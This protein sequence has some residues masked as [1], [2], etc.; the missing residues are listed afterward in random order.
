MSAKWAN[1]YPFKLFGLL[2]A[3]TREQRLE[4]ARIILRDRHCMKDGFT[5]NYLGTF[6]TPELL[7]SSASIATLTGVGLLV[8]RQHTAK[9]EASPSTP[10]FFSDYFRSLR[11]NPDQRGQWSLGPGR[12]FRIMTVGPLGVLG[13]GGSLAPSFSGFAVSVSHPPPFLFLGRGNHSYVVRGVC[14]LL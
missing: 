7:A 5:L 2:A 10:A 8:L 3:Q 1:T 12:G 9:G 14:S 13:L 6:S 11:G 4:L